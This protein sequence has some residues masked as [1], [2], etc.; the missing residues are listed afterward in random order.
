M[1][2]ILDVPPK[3]TGVPT[4]PLRRAVDNLTQ[5]ATR[6]AHQES[7]NNRIRNR[8]ISKVLPTAQPPQPQP[9]SLDAFKEAITSK[10]ASTY[11]RNKG[12]S[13]NA[14]AQLDGLAQRAQAAGYPLGNADVQDAFLGVLMSY[15]TD[16]FKGEDTT[17]TQMGNYKGNWRGAVSRDSDWEQIS[18]GG[19]LGKGQSVSSSTVVM[20]PI[21][22]LGLV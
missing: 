18:W 20:R 3:V 12:P 11:G 14:L 5:V 8:Y 10:I 22:F 6:V 13:Q 1:Q 2:S 21:L 9:P 17:G 15:V 4:I 19:S 7:E 16:G